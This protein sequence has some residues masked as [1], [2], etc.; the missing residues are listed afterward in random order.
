M[1]C[2]KIKKL[3]YE[4]FDK[5][6]GINEKN[7]VEE[8]I[9]D[10]AGCKNIYEEV[11]K[12][13]NSMKNIAADE[14]PEGFTYRLKE[15]IEMLEE[16]KEINIVLPSVAFVLGAA[17]VL[18]AVFLKSNIRDPVRYIS[19]DNV[20]TLAS[21]TRGS[22][23]FEGSPSYLKLDIRS[24]NNLDGVSLRIT[25]P[26]GLVLSNNS[27]KA[28]WHGDLSKGQN[29]ILLRVKG[30]AEGTWNIEGV[31]EKNGQE[32]AFAQKVRVI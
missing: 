20:A 1:K 8:H 29:V 14:V 4:N 28:E 15:K 24:E 9:I 18:M 30:R 16:K 13:L 5:E 12:M 23:L 6:A 25:L 2:K 11:S 22:M 7:T 17:V 31:I 3:I 26:Y 19:P 27:N 21:Y 10:C 32:K